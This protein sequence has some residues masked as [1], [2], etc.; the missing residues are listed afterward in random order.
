MLICLV[1]SDPST[2]TSLSPCT[3]SRLPGLTSQGGKRTLQ[4][5]KIRGFGTVPG[6]STPRITQRPE[7]QFTSGLMSVKD[8][9]KSFCTHQSA[10]ELS[11]WSLSYCSSKID[12]G[13]VPGDSSPHCDNHPAISQKI[14]GVLRQ[15]VQHMKA[16]E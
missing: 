14:L 8:Q 7:R 1:F 11:L 4:R 9:E 13:N 12:T 3:G 16:R 5:P 10:C 15:A 6:H 2:R